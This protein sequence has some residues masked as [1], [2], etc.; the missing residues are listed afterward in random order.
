[1]LTNRVARKVTGQRVQIYGFE[2]YGYRRLPPYHLLRRIQFSD[3][4]LAK[5]IQ[6]TFK[7]SR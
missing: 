5:K 1:M 7:R 4:G 2:D 6:I 3:K